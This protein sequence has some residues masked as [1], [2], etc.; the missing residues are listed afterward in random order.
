MLVPC[1]SAAARVF[2]TRSEG[3]DSSLPVGHIGQALGQQIS[4]RD[5][6]LKAMSR[7][8]ACLGLGQRRAPNPKFAHTE[9]ANAIANF[10]VKRG[11]S[12]QNLT[13]ESRRSGGDAIDRTSGFGPEVNCEN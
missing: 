8:P 9:R 7:C 6:N 10:G 13:L 1:A 11:T 5:K 12:G 2:D 4:H 3:E